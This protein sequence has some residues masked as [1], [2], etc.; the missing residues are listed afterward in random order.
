MVRGGANDPQSRTMDAAPARDADTGN[1][2]SALIDAL[3]SSAS[4]PLP[5]GVSSDIRRDRVRRRLLLRQAGVAAP[6]GRGR[7]ACAGRAESQRSRMARVAET[8]APEAVPKVMFENGA[9]GWFVMEYLPP[10]AYPVWKGQ[11]RDGVID[12]GSRCRRS[13]ANSRESMRRPPA[14]AR[15]RER[16]ATDH[17]FFPIRAEPYLI[18]P[19]GAHPEL[20]RRTGRARATG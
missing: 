10:G 16:F 5:G 15:S 19:V 13:A 3:A 9:A 1:P 14:M 4:T 2:L 17:I 20:C 6:Q 7:M 12:S 11:L 8:I 18:A